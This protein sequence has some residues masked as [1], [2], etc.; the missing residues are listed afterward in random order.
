[1]HLIYLIGAPGVG[2]STAMRAATSEWTAVPAERDRSVPGWTPHVRLIDG[3]GIV[4]AIELGVRREPFGGT[5]GLSMSIGPQ[6]A[7]FLYTHPHRLVLGE[8]QRLATRP[9]LEAA[10]RAGYSTTLVLLSL[11]PELAAERWAGR[12]T[13]Q[14]S[15]WRKG[16]E[17]RVRNIAGWAAA[18]GDLVVVTL[19]AS[20]P[21]G[22]IGDEIRD[23]M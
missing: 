11:P 1:M 17:T 21:P 12:G 10:V 8:G 18:R 6:A 16:A 3:D 7:D 19:D 23:L 15:S 5:D 4:R 9:F 20:G 13:D 2:K 22:F 14:A